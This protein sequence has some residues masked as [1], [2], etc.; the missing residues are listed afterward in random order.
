MME[1]SIRRKATAVPGTPVRHRYRQ[2]LV[3][4]AVGL[5]ILGWLLLL[6]R[7]ASLAA[8]PLPAPKWYQGT[9]NQSFLP[10]VIRDLPPAATET[11]TVT[12]TQTNTA[13]STSTST[14]TATPTSTPSPSSTATGTATAS[15]TAT[16][17]ST[18]TSTGTGTVTGLP[19][20]QTITP[21]PTATGTI[22]PN[23]AVAKRVSPT[24]AAIGQTFDF[25]IDVTNNGSAPA[26]DAVLSD[27]F[28][29][30]LDVQSATSTKGSVS[31][32]AHSVTVV[33][34][35]LNPAEKVTV[36]I[37]VKINNSPTRTETSN[38]TATLTYNGNLTRTGTVTYKALISTL[39]GTGQLPL[40]WN[41]PPPNRTM[42]TQWILLG[43]LG[44]VVFFYGLW[45]RR[46][47]LRHAPWFM[48]IGLTLAGAA[49]VG[50]LALSGVFNR[51]ATFVATDQEM[52]VAQFE[53]AAPTPSR[54][55]YMPAYR[56]ATPEA[57]PQ[58][59]L[60]SFPIPS[61]EVSVT[62]GADEEALDTSPVERII[63]PALLV[64]TVVKYVPFDGVSWY[65]TG[66][67][68]EVAWMGDTS[69]PG[70]GGNT[71][72]AGHVTVLG[73]GDGPFRYL[74]ELP[75]GETIIL[76]T[77]QNRYV[78]K[79]REQ[80]VVEVDDFS[81][82]APSENPML[83]LVTCI[84]WDDENSMYVKRL[85]VLAD[86]IDTQSLVTRGEDK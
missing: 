33:I 65:I 24:Q 52:P 49:L 67:R 72:L 17:T 42:L 50:G 27:S 79:V 12:A 38:N 13:T 57:I 66:L 28:A 59:T 32:T 44:V 77:D 10:I 84:E 64:D 23:P 60:P 31:R 82:L 8:E 61:P 58:V 29:S 22:T 21:T 75:V 81:V 56:Y 70:L 43:F 63:I 35:N 5:L 39:P 55:P 80:R 14:T 73:M 40:D 69:W 71:A 11:P 36:T 54:M 68:D 4:I 26:L 2:I 20:T 6:P 46:N 83:T 37:V 1:G 53:E 85:V 15:P 30:Y 78:Y 62:P 76:H 51:P 34:G 86:L 48:G 74:E 9:T 47:G 18:P 16:Q 7:L 3:C 19:G 41:D 25:T 45:G